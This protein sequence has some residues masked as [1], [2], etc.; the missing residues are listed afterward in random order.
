LLREKIVEIHARRLLIIVDES[1]IVPRL[2]SHGPLPVEI[3]PFESEAHIRWLNTLGCRAELW[4]D[5]QD[6][7]WVTDNHNF[8]ARCWFPQGIPDA[9]ELARQLESRPGIVE[10][11]LFL[12]LAHQVIVAGVDGVHIMER[13]H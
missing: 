9:K 3:V 2:G 1:K 8:L 12:N 13:N 10:H 11:G 6:R 5:N 4:L 7:P